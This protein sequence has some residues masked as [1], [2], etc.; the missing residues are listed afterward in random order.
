M[1]L[2]LAVATM[3]PARAI[4]P[5]ANASLSCSVTDPAGD[6]FTSPN[7]PA[8]AWEDIIGATVDG[9]GRR[10][11]LTLV[12]NAT[13]PANPPTDSSDVPIWW[14][15]G[16]SQNL[17]FAPTGWPSSPGNTG[18]TTW[19]DAA[20]VWDG[21][22]FSGVF[23]NRLNGTRTTIPFSVSGAT[24]T[25]SVDPALMGDPAFLLWAAFIIVFTSHE[26]AN[27]LKI[28][29]IAPNFFTTGELG[30]WPC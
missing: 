21:S 10:F 23:A 22:A 19:W 6:A 25:L 15:F 17:S 11:I 14:D 16:F 9:S 24:I 26:G 30:S 2:A 8:P 12:L 29:D 7:H 4:V 27:S 1:V 20:L 18:H 3:P 28:P 13:I 5:A